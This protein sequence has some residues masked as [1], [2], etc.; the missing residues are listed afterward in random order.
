[1]ATRK[2]AQ[3]PMQKQFSETYSEQRKEMFLH[4][5]RELTGRAKQRQL[6]KGKA[7]DWEKFNEYFNNFYADATAD[8][9]LEEIS[10]MFIG[11]HRSKQSLIC[12]SAISAM[13]LKQLMLRKAKLTVKISTPMTSSIS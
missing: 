7:L 5:A 11:S 4:V 9:I 12:I 2:S 13:L 10:T 1:M 3:S 6:P 8:E